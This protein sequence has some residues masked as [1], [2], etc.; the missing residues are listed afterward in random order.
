M[1]VLLYAKKV[2]EIRVLGDLFHKRAVGQLFAL[3][4]N[5]G[6]KRHPQRFRRVSFVGGKQTGVHFFKC[7][8]VDSC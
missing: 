1:R 7:A 3:L 4:D 5:E 6:P 8:P 2:L